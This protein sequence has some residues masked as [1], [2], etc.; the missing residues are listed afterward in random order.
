MCHIKSC[1]KKHISIFLLPNSKWKKTKRFKE[2]AINTF[3]MSFIKDPLYFFN[4]YNS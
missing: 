1:E 3:L 2:R 4:V